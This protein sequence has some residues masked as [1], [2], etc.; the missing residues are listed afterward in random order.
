MSDWR[1]TKI[2]INSVSSH[3]DPL[4]FSLCRGGV[5]MVHD[6]SRNET[7]VIDFQGA[8]P[9]TLTE[10]MLRNASELEVKHMWGGGQN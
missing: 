2:S 7:R 8:A 6:I 9:K 1:L 4:L 10:E 5:M 3:V